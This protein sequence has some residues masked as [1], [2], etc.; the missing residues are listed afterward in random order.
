MRVL[1][2]G[3]GAREHAIAWK[4]ALSPA[5]N[6]IYCAPGNGGTAMIAQNLD[7]SVATEPE[8]DQLAGWAF[9]NKMDLVIIGPEGPLSQGMVDTLMMFGVP[10]VGPTKAASKLEWSKSWGKEFMRKHGIPTAR[11]EVVQGMSAIREKLKSLDKFFPVV[12]KADGLAAGKGTE[13]IRS[14]QEVE[15]AL[16]RL[17]ST[18]ALQDADEAKVVIEEYLKGIEVSAIAFVDGRNV[19]MMPPACDY[20]RLLDGD[21]GPVTG[22]MGAY[23]PTK[24]VTPELWA[25]VE[26]EIMLKVVQGMLSDGI[27]YRGFLFAGLMLTDDGPKVLEFDCRLG[28]PEAQVLL[29]RL[30]TPLEE[31][32]M[33]MAGGNLAQI[34]AIEWDDK[35]VVGVVIA[36]EGY[37]TSQ[38]VPQRVKGLAD[39]QEGVLVFHSGS[40]L[41][42]A[43]A[44]QPVEV[45]ATKPSV[46]QSL[47]GRSGRETTDNLR[48]DFLSP[49]VTATGGR[50]LTV[51]AR[52]RTVAEARET[53]YRNIKRIQIPAT[54]YRRD[55]GAREA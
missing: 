51:V 35:A 27:P 55:I 12:V 15:D 10:V 44:L 28:D 50:L 20:K 45:G 32:G 18:G 21:Q 11:Y 54:Q 1:V 30:K 46:I 7:M 34:G 24:Y 42:G 3:S 9:N 23:T 13:V 31:I 33:A 2:V 48:S 25:R 49:K 16:T 40:R 5:V 6:D 52:G 39:V 14:R 36:S 37:P 19:A 17:I 29:P 47:F 53:V 41:F 8:C 38:S 26:K 43:T 4:L 22:G